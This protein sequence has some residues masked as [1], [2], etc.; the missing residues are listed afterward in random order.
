MKNKHETTATDILT[1][2]SVHS[3]RPYL[4][5]YSKAQ[6][7]FPLPLYPVHNSHAQLTSFVLP[8]ILCGS[9]IA[10]AF[11]P[12]LTWYSRSHW[13]QISTVRS[14]KP[15]FSKHESKHTTQLLV[16]ALHSLRTPSPSSSSCSGAT[17][18][19]VSGAGG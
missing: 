11:H 3:V 2:K 12:L 19:P 4:V 13:S 9:P 5:S 18:S 8:C 7:L 17:S 16:K 15:P 10:P 14:E 1:N 6:N